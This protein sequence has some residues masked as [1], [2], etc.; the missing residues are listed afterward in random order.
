MNSIGLVSLDYDST[1]IDT[2]AVLLKYIKRKAKLSVQLC[3]RD[4]PSGK[5][6]DQHFGEHVQDFFSPAYVSIAYRSM[7]PFPGAVSFIK[8]LKSS[9]FKVIIV[10]KNINS[11]QEQVKVSHCSRHFGLSSKDILSVRM[12][13][14]KH[15]YTENSI[16]ID[17]S[18]H[19][20]ETH[21]EKN[22]NPGVLFNIGS[23][24]GWVRPLEPNPL[25]AYAT[26]FGT[27]F[28]HTLRLT[29]KR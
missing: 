21:L 15:L 19:N 16:L 20:I 25:Y 11:V 29:G 28:R 5:F 8:A 9:G 2:Q 6:L 18:T 3:S 10:T 1:L 7:I 23:K 17:D 27:A 14:E 13:D 24:H 12:E 22:R 26:T 4:I